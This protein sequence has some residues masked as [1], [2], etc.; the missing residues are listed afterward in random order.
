MLHT[1]KH[2]LESADA[3]RTI[4]VFKENNANSVKS[5][6]QRGSLISDNSQIKCMPR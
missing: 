3:G 5:H 6:C 4:Y 2:R 1:Q